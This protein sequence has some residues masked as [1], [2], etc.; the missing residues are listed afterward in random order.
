MTTVYPVYY[1]TH[2]VKGAPAV[3]L[4]MGLGSDLTRWSPDFLADLARD[5]F[6]VCIENRDSGR[7]LQPGDEVV[8][9]DLRDMAAD[10]LAVMD[11]LEQLRFTTVGFSMGGMIAQ[12]V[13]ITAPHRVERMVQICSSGGE[14]PPALCEGVH[15][16]FERTVAPFDSREEMID[17]LTESYRHFSH[18]NPLSREETRASVIE[19]LD[20]GF[21]QRGYKRQ[22]EAIRA[23]PD[24]R[25]E[26]QQITAPALVIGSEQ[27]NCLPVESSCSAAQLIPNAELVLFA[28]KGHALDAEILETVATWLRRG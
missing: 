8:P 14:S 24:R 1:E 28:N 9:Y 2:G 13:A 4:S 5:H 7:S 6:V 22:Y 3:A 15:E 17:F 20:S 25:V 27:D 11:E 26:L 16:Q 19:R 23:T 18:P 10:V 12:L 21:S